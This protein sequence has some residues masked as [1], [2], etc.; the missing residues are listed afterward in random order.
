MHTLIKLVVPHRSHFLGGFIVNPYSCGQSDNTELLVFF[1]FGR[2]F[3]RYC[4][5]DCK[6]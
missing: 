3:M 5:E 2:M 6:N 1:L 4:F